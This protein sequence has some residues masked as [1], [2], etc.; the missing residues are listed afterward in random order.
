MADSLLFDERFLETHAGA[1]ITDPEVAI[2]EL[3]ANAWDAWATE[4]R[5]LWSEKGDERIF[6]ISDNGKG[7]T[8]GEFQRRW[9]TIS[10][11]R[12]VDQGTTSEPP[13]ELHSFAP[14][15][16]YGRNG[17]G[18]HAAFRFGDPYQVR[19]W[20]DGLELTYLV[21]RGKNQP[22]EVE[23]IA[24]RNGIPG[25][26]TEISTP[27]GTGSF[28]PA[29]EVREIL[30]TRFLS[31][32]NFS[33]WVDGTKV[34]FGDVPAARLREIQF[35]VPE[36]GQVHITVI[37]AQR[38]D[39]TTRQH[40]IAWWVQSRLVGK[41]GW[42]GFDHERILDGRTAEAKRFSFIVRADYLANSGAVLADWTG[43]DSA[44]EAWT[45]TRDAAHKEI[46]EVLAEYTSQ[47][48]ADTKATVRTKLESQVSRL[49]P[50]SRDKWNNF[51]DDVVDSCPSITTDEVEQVAGILAKLEHAN[52][53]YA[54]LNQLHELKPGEFDELHA[55]LSDWSVRTAKLA[56]DEIQS[57]LKLIAE[58]DTK[59]RDH[60]LD[61]VG[62]LQPLFERSLW[63]FGPEFESLEFTSNRG[64]TEVIRKIFGRTETG[65]RLR[66][67]FV[68]LGDGSVGFYSRDAHDLG[69]EVGGVARLVITEIKKVGVE[70]G[71]TEKG[72]PWKYIAE[73]INKGLLTESAEVTAYVLGSKLDPTEAEDDTRWGGRV[74]IRPMTYDVFI[75]RAEKRLL[76]LRQKLRD[77]PFLSEAGFDP[78]A[79]T[80]PAMP[81]QGQLRLERAP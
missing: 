45:R 65:S 81:V 7:M 64:M 6:S 49:P 79:F 62:D 76:G 69:H 53:K 61:E 56:L 29:Q 32:P 75:R 66:P 72:Q 47:R 54:L 3:V 58:L 15:A 55:L 12:L 37:D 71:V 28:L 50:I 39:K 46:R 26:G 25:H 78:I 5:I 14:R 41:S 52:S 8:E 36:C 10:Y 77:A 20:R 17:K 1:I 24:R 35:E 57:R 13:S 48:R 63:V 44:N 16:A 33:V 9:K 67:D 2:V 34:T 22:F 4:V 74:T 27:H 18:R 21:K 19:T 30:G 59:L 42:V 11:N 73:L 60:T 38:V 40:G 70:I 51:V 68:M 80:E 23:E 43:F 31:D